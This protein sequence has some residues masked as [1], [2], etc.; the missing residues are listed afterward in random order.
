MV[1]VQREAGAA[2]IRDVDELATFLTR[3]RRVGR[4]LNAVLAEDSLREDLWRIMHALAKS[5]GMLMGEIAEEL[6]LPPATTTRLVDELA[7]LGILFRRPAPDD[8]RKAV[9]YLSRLGHERLERIEA[10]LRARLL[11]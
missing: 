10:L 7:D 4:A 3:A 6:A 2:S 9:V 5:H 1:S 8:G 11:D